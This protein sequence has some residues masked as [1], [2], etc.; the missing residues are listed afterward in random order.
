MNRWAVQA[1]VLCGSLLAI[2]GCAQPSGTGSVATTTAGA[3]CGVSMVTDYSPVAGA[4]TGSP[5]AAVNAWLS[6]TRHDLEA[7][8]AGY[9]KSD[10]TDRALVA[11]LATLAALKGVDEVLV[12]EKVAVDAATQVAHLRGRDSHG[13]S[14]DITISGGS[15]DSPVWMV[16][17]YSLDVPDTLC[18]QL[19]KSKTS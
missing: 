7:T 6:A 14:V 11:D 1:V 17:G 10:P 19:R 16:T 3:A 2:M 4:S 5:E 8:T 12:T 18:T 9:A 15:I 13:R